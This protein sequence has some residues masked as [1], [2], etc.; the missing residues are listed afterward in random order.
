[1]V[2]ASAALS[3]TPGAVAY[4]LAKAAVHHLVQTAA[5]EGSGMPSGSRTVGICPIML[6]TPM[7][8]KFMPDS[9]FSTWTGLQD[10]ADP[11]VKWTMER[12]DLPLSGALYQLSTKDFK[13]T[14]SQ[15]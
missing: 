15:V 8:R 10:V 11:L 14:W 12:K 7:N 9:D 6:D 1:M 2:G 5:S 13:T 3:P 4:G